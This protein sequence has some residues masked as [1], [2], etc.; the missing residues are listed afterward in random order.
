[1]SL[2]REDPELAR[3][4]EDE[5]Q[6]VEFFREGE[7]PREQW[8]VGTEHEKI[9]LYA[10]SLAPVP[11]EG[12]RGIHALLS[13]LE[14]EHGF[15]PLL[16]GERLVGLECDGANITLE[17]GG[18]LELSGAPLVSLHETCR[19]FNEHL[20]L[21]KHVSERFG[22]VWLGLGIHPLATLAEL[23]RMP[24][25]RYT[26]M[27][28]HM[29]RQGELGLSMMHAT[30][31]VQAN[32]DYSSE[33]DMAR[34][35]RVAMAASPVVTALYANSS[36]SEGEPN[37]FESR[38][39]WVWRHTDPDRCGMLPFVFEDDFDEGHAYRRYAQWALDVPLYFIVRGGHHVRTGGITFREFLER[40]LGEERATLADWYIHLTTL[41]PENRLKRVIEVRGADAVPPG[42]VCALPALWKGLL[43]DEQSL[44]AAGA[45]LGHWTW[46]E[47]DR[48]HGE[49]ARSGLKA[50]TPDGPVLA[51]ARELA[52]V[53]A[54]GLG[55]LDARSRTGDDESVFLDP[56]FENIDRGSSP[57]RHL[58]ECWDGAWSRR[59]ELLVEYAK[60]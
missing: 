2:T 59:I 30:G 57:A 16:D 53:S 50:D 56:L 18:Q 37:G 4:L 47:V 3:P 21:M 25:E 10:E 26:I 23:P 33:A 28:E 58:L 35:L 48:L 8:R 31:T 39:A 34:K 43:Y 17:P 45:R 14:R 51:L 15:G 1:M 5:A 46:A 42:L 49:V 13:V 41:F 20:A 27:R 9:A 6:L 36:V 11:Y 40:G 44:A 55:R 60:Y 32:F 24:R 12:D 22:I 52:D 7:T 38:R 54:A 29:A 19:E